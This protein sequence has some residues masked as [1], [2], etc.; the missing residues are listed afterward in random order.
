MGFSQGAIMSY[1]TLSRSSELI[2]GII[3][4]SGRLLQETS[5]D[6]IDPDQYGDKRIFIGHGVDDQV[7]PVT[8]TGPIAS[9]IRSL[10]IEP[11]LK[12]YDI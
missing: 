6:D 7:I 3:G 9:Y 8:E 12:F 1:Y 10:G 2:R 4:L 5:S 11:V